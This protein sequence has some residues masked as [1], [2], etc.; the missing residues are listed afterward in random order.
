MHG[1]S[2]GTAVAAAGAR[3]N[4]D[5]EIVRSFAAEDPITDEAKDTEHKRQEKE[6]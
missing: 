6:R 1:S 4:Y 5:I 3:T 2:T